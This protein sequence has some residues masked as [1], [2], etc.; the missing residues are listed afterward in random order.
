MRRAREVAARLAP[1]CEVEIVPIR[2]DGERRIDRPIDGAGQQ[3]F[4]TKQ[5]ETALSRKRIDVGVHALEDL[6][7]DP[8]PRLE[9]AAILARGDAR[10]A[11][12][13]HEAT[14]A[15]AMAELPRGSR[16]ATSNWRRR[17]QLR[18]D[19]PDLEVVQV[20]GDLA[21]RIRRLD[22]GRMHAL[23]CSASALDL[24]EIVQRPSERIDPP[25]WLPAAGQGAIA[26]Q[27]RKGDDETRDIVRRLH[28][29]QTEVHTN[30]ERAL[31]RALFDGAQAPVA[32]TIVMEGVV[33]VLHG[34]IGDPDGDRVVRAEHTLDPAD[35][36]GT[37][38]RLASILR[39][40]GGEQIIES[41]RE[42]TDVPHPQPD[43]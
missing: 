10:D 5:L 25:L 4:F 33:P 39:L 14:G 18:S 41:L 8:P 22:A 24:L 20:H 37:G 15:L 35:P 34:M 21:E 31:T 12:L 38:E 42:R 2:V 16:V 29:R 17:M 19:W 27:I 36:V 26:L 40:R 30:A 23:I 43:S 3:R 1:W 11:A 32:A 6:E 28:D 13:F 7:T 9:I